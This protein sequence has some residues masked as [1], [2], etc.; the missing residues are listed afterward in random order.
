MR[1]GERDAQA[2]AHEHHH[3]VDTARLLGEVF[4]VAGK[5]NSRV[6]DDALLHRRRDHRGIFAGEA[7]PHRAIEQRED[8]AAI[9][10][11]ELS[12]PRRPGERNVLH[13]GDFR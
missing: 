5:R 10:G 6:V 13:I 3:H 12:G 2:A 1:G 9:G 8:V 11:V 4:R 7:A